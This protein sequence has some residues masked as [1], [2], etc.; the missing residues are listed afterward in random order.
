MRLPPNYGA[1]TARTSRARYQRVADTLG[2]KRVPFFLKGVADAE[3]PTG[4]V[5][6]PTGSIRG[7]RRSR[8]CWNNIVVGGCWG[9]C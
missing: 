5:S 4:A 2:A 8:C 3:D 6:R 7:G 9:R 1:A